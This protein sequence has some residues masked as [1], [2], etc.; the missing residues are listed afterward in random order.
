MNTFPFE[1]ANGISPDTERKEL[2]LNAV[3]NMLQN[4][5]RTQ[6]RPRHV[7]KPPPGNLQR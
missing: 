6:L 5:G 3:L 1:F 4:Q 2:T 7:E